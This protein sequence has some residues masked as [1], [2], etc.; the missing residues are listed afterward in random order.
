MLAGLYAI[1][2]ASQGND[3]AIISQVTQALEGGAGIVQLR[4]K[5]RSSSELVELGLQLKSLCR[6]HDALFI[7]DDRL[8]L[9]LALDAD[10]LHIGKDDIDFEEARA[11]LPG[12]ILGVS[13]YGSISRAERFE[14][15]GADYAA[16]GSF[17]P[18]PTKPG[19]GIVPESVITRAKERLKIPVCAIGGI[20]TGNADSLVERGA[21][22]LAV[23]SALWQSDNIRR[24]AAAFSD[25][26]KKEHIA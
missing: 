17:F 16:F 23:V 7:I 25:Y 24:A 19:S 11:A 5:Q 3:R 26:F 15:L 4:D 10:G 22:M 2:D 9:A 13:C 21:D 1:T 18:S 8:E 6:H 20:T 14:A 12:K